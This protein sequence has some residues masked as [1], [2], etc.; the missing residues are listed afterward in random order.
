MKIINMFGFGISPP[1]P[2]FSGRHNINNKHGEKPNNKLVG[3]CFVGEIPI[4]NMFMVFMKRKII[5]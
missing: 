4:L 2:I 3:K 5:N 1:Q